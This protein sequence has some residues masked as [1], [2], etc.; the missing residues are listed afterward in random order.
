MPEHTPNHFLSPDQNSKNVNR[1]Q[2][3][4]TRREFTALGVAGMSAG[5]LATN[6]LYSAAR[7]LAG[8]GSIE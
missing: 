7:S 5:A 1:D 3:S 8:R 2:N 6:P 4:L